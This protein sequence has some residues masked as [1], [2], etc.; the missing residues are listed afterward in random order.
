MPFTVLS[1]IIQKM[2]KFSNVIFDLDG[3]L[4]DTQKDIFKSFREASFR[5]FGLTVDNISFKIGPPLEDIVRSYFPDISSDDVKSFINT[6]RSIYLNCGFDNTFCYQ[7]IEDL[8]TMLKRSK[9]K[10]FLATNKPG[11]L[12]KAIISKLNI[13]YFDD[14]VTIDSIDGLILSKKEMISLQIEKSKLEQ[15]LTVMIGDSFS[16]IKSARENSIISIG[17]GYGYEVKE[18]IQKANPDYFF[19]TVLQLS[20][21]L[22]GI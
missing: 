8:L 12:T 1:N 16:D 3:T 18:Q 17:V 9:K 19:E 7:G 2:Y 4:I 10:I 6:F 21:F 5:K 11:F 22:T 13:D 20:H 14:I 15:R